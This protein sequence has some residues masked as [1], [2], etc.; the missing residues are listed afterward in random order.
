MKTFVHERVMS[1]VRHALSAT[2]NEN[3][4]HCAAMLVCRT[5]LRYPA[6]LNAGTPVSASDFFETQAPARGCPEDASK[7]QPP[8]NASLEWERFKRDRRIEVRRVVHPSLCIACGQS[9][10][11]DEHVLQQVDVGVTHAGCAEWWRDVDFA[12]VPRE[13]IEDVLA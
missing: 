11:I 3:E 8:D 12:R 10:D 6:L 4:A 1:L 7:V 9:F 5:L 2:A 13:G